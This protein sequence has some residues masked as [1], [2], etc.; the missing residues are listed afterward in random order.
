MPFVITGR[1]RS[2]DVAQVHRYEHPR[3]SYTEAG[4]DGP[5]AIC[6]RI[7]ASVRLARRTSDRLSSMLRSSSL[8]QLEWVAISRMAVQFMIQSPS[9]DMIAPD[10]YHTEHAMYLQQ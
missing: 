5:L 2:A 4:H 7:C 10:M 3:A 9:A 6:R 1:L 8:P